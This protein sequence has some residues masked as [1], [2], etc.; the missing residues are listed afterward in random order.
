MCGV[1]R[2]Y[3]RPKEKENEIEK[4]QAMEIA[5]VLRQN[6]NRDGYLLRLHGVLHQYVY[7]IKNDSAIAL[8][9]SV[10]LTVCSKIYTKRY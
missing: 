3:Q 6:G 5:M 10:Q 7:E 8:S 2:A 9:Y 4:W 1:R